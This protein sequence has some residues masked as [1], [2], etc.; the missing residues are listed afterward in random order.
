MMVQGHT[1]SGLEAADR[2]PA[3][4]V[5][6]E[7][8]RRCS[9]PGKKTVILAGQGALGAGDELE[10]MADTLAAPIVKALLGKAVVPD[11]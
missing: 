7:R 3:G 4:G 10:Q 1:S 5:A 8:P 11:D 6:R 9:T 2:R